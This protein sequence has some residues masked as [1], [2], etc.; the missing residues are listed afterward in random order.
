MTTT[1]D[2]AAWVAEQADTI[3]ERSGI[4]SDTTRRAAIVD[5]VRRD[6]EIAGESGLER[7]VAIQSERAG[8]EP[9][10][11]MAVGLA[12]A[13]AGNPEAM[14][15]EIDRVRQA[16]TKCEGG[17]PKCPFVRRAFETIALAAPDIVRGTSAQTCARRLA[18]LSLLHV[19]RRDPGLLRDVFTAEAAARSV[20]RTMPGGLMAFATDRRS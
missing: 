2:G 4:V 6:P 13:A 8:V 3:M 20:G 10:D 19:F 9:G 7:L 16:A 15:R 1:S 5:A 14:D 18:W 11:A 12:V 17:K